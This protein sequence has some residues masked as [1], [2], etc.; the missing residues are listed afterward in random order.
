MK[1]FNFSSSSTASAEALKAAEVSH[2]LNELRSELGEYSF[3]YEIANEFRDLAIEAKNK[4]QDLFDF[5]QSYLQQLKTRMEI[6]QIWP[7]VKKTRAD[8]KEFFED[9]TI[10]KESDFEK[11]E[12]KEGYVAGYRAKKNKLIA[13]VCRS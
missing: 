5:T 3:D 9:K 10:A 4:Q 8:L 13:P 7:A 1:R 2:Y 6:G 12:D 11:S